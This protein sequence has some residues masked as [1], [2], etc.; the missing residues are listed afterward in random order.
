[1]QVSL[2]AISYGTCSVPCLSQ[3]VHIILLNYVFVNKSAIFYRK[4][5]EFYVDTITDG[6]YHTFIILCNIIIDMIFNLPEG[7]QVFGIQEKT[8]NE[9]RYVPDLKVP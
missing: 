8:W 9:E 7:W 2:A 1:M 4:N 5:F 3:Y 6:L